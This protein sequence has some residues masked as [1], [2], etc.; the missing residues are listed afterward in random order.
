[1]NKQELETENE[2]L[3]ETLAEVQQQLQKLEEVVR[4]AL[5]SAEEE[6]G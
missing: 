4:D 2:R 1:M 5:D 3:L 6:E